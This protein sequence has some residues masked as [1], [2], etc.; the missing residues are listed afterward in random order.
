MLSDRVFEN[1]FK[2]SYI[3]LS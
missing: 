3:H 1:A 2:Y